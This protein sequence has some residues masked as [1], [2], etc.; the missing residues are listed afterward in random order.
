MLLLLP[1]GFLL[2]VSIAILILQHN[3]RS[4]GLSWLVAALATI[5]IWLYV[6]VMRWLPLQPV[7][8]ENVLPATELTQGITLTLAG[9]AWPYALAIV[10]S[11]AAVVL[12]SA[13]QLQNN[14]R[15]WAWAGSMA[16]AAMG[17]LGV[18]SNTP[19]ALI[20]TW[21]A[22]DI[23]ELATI[24][25]SMEGNRFARNAVVAFSTRIMGTLVLIW[26]MVY[27]RSFGQAL[28]LSDPLPQVGLYLL[29][30]AGLRLGVLP[31]NMPYTSEIPLRRGLVTIIRMVTSA[32]SLVLLGRLPAAAVPAD[33]APY[34][35]IFAA[36]AAF[37]GAVMFLN[38]KDELTG[39][40]FFLIALGGLA[41]GCVV[42]SYPQ[43]SQ[44]WGTALLISG[45]MLFLNSFRPKRAWVFTLIGAI[46]L[47]GLPFT[48]AASG[49]NGVVVL[50]FNIPDI[51]FTLAHA[52][53][54][55]GYLHQG[56]KPG[57]I[58]PQSERWIEAAYLLGL[59]LLAAADWVIAI[60]GWEG[61]FILGEWWASVI[62]LV[63]VAG[64]YF[65]L[66]RFQTAVLSGL[67]HVN[68]LVVFSGHLTRQIEVFFTFNWLNRIVSVIYRLTQRIV[69]LLTETLEGEGGLLWV[70]VLLTLLITLIGAGGQ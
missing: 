9:G 2:A 59:I 46:G 24:L 53:L 25:V 37:Y 64:G 49:W 4:Q 55:L 3:R 60:F 50:P 44:A 13:A 67:S 18:F 63:L 29:L 61:S 1:V 58:L 16:V 15:P 47:I 66:S 14:A 52:L 62:S 51:V 20:L 40:P 35:L 65:G 34:L 39:R 70:F 42:R 54:V 27:S 22:L 6:L 26:A 5:L 68:W 10:T 31:L 7:V 23:M 8:L 48:P 56:L 41:V 30:A 17:L 21:T 36:M 43:S 45:S 12:T 28:N 69:Y 57:P 11:L 33:W 32:T 38:A 19:L